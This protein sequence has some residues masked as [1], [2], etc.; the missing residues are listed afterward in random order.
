MSQVTTAKSAEDRAG[1]IAQLGA[2]DP[3]GR[4]TKMATEWDLLSNK[5]AGDKTYDANRLS[6]LENLGLDKGTGAMTDAEISKAYRDKG[7]SDPVQW[8][9]TVGASEGGATAGSYM[10]AI[11]SSGGAASLQMNLWSSTADAMVSTAAILSALAG[12]VKKK[13]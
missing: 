12:K 4:L 10:A 13:E 11:Q 8:K 6:L 5:G 9:G 3:T 7:Y 1:R 2:L